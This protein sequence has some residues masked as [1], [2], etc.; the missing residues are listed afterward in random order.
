MAMRYADT[1]VSTELGY[2]LDINPSMYPNLSYKEENLIWLATY[3]NNELGELNKKARISAT[4]KAN[5]KISKTKSK[6]K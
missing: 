1:L 5:R 3:I 6:R 2:T 4:R